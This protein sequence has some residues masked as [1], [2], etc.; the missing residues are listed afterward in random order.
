MAEIEHLTNIEGVQIAHLRAFGD[1]RGR[2]LETFRKEW[3]P[4][5]R[6][7]KVQTNRSE[8]Q[9]GVLRGLHYHHHQVDY[10]YVING[11]IRVALADLRPSSPTHLATHVLEMSGDE[12]KGMFIPIGVA[13]GFLTLED[14]TLTYLVDN[15][16]DGG[17]DEYGVIWNDPDLDVA[18]GA[19]DPIL[20][21]RDAANPRWRDIPAQQLPR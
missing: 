4:Q 19:T 15:Y 1:E 5:R 20:S 7:E 12:E 17:R 21:P 2:F 10:W 6:W 11:R 8:S 13:H 18:W 3:F 14:A 16:Y 9:A